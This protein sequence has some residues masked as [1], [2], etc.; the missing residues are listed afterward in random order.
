MRLHA[1]D[2]RSSIVVFLVALP[3]CLGIALASGAPLAA[4]IMAGIIG[5]IVV[6]AFSGSAVSVSGPAA[7]LTVIVA[8]AITELGGMP[9]F[10]AALLLAGVLQ[11]IMG[12]CRAGEL[13][14]F[15]PAAVIKGMLAAIGLILILKQLPHAVGWDADYMGDESFGS[16]S[17]ENTF[18]GLMHA[19]E[20]L[21]FGA[22][23]VAL[24]G[25][26]LMLLWDKVL[27]KKFPRL[28][29]FPSA[30]LAVLV[31]VLL[32]RY[33]FMGSP[34]WEIEASH[35]VQLPFEG[36]FAS[37]AGSMILPDFSALANPVTWRVALTLAIVAS[38]ETLL[39]L[40]AADKLD[41]LKRLSKKDRELRAQGIGNTL[42]ALVGGL[43]MTAVIVR[44]SANIAGGGLHRTSAI[45][46]GLW[47]LAAV[48]AFPNVL[49][50]I[51][52]SALAAVLLLVGWK[53]TSPK[54]FKLEWSKGYAQ[55]VPFV[56]TIIAILFTDLLMGI[57]IGLMVG[58]VFVLF[59]NSRSSILQINQEGTTLVRF[60]KD[61]S[62]LQK[63]RL[64][65]I[66]EDLPDNS[67]IVI[68]GSR[69]I[70]VDND[71]EELV[72]DFVESA[73][74]RNIHV[75]LQKSSLALSP[76]FKE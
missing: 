13:G 47:L 52:L 15:F 21:H 32:N 1:S 75:R 17:G 53:L 55:F 70:Y 57:G 37:F 8:G 44:T 39:S 25:I 48:V 51:P 64:R 69:S 2:L 59:A 27:I 66:L 45:F 36:G 35:L 65:G 72:E 3:L 73:P 46:H 54:L 16:V 38:L 76:L 50:Y 10:G 5:G 22:T 12:F 71:I 31:G 56:V 61:V 28:S 33:A 20:R 40:D 26:S 30:L 49:N 60:C 41:P 14:N 67:H 4:G 6:G 9:A 18:S 34:D 58:L 11:V 23:T 43:P 24:V 62:F 42:S 7:G 63:A 29:I 68:D 74:G 19:W